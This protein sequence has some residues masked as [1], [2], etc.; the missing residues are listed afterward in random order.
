VR[1]KA[2]DLVCTWLE[3]THTNV[4]KLIHLVGVDENYEAAE[5]LAHNLID[6]I[7]KGNLKT[8]DH[9]KEVIR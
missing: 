9:I 5:L 8:S 3:S 2:F 6:A 4:P 1:E 7:E